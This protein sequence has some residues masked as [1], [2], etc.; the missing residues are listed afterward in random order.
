MHE[1]Q[2]VSSS[3]AARCAASGSEDEPPGGE[4]EAS[5][6]GSGD[7]A[8]A[9]RAA[10]EDED[11]DGGDNVHDEHCKECNKGGELLLCDG[12]NCSTAMHRS[13][14]RLDRVPDGDW[15]CV[16]CCADDDGAIG[17]TDTKETRGTLHQLM[18]RQIKNGNWWF[19]GR[20]KD[21]SKIGPCMQVGRG[22]IG[23]MGA[24][25]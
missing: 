14:A 16:D 3:A 15:F 19:Y 7:P 8:G 24:E 17:I 25:K 5:P 6:G 22:R 18:A 4:D 21:D 2:K 12:K 23:D 10:A 13:C 11:G 20:Y 1:K 9:R